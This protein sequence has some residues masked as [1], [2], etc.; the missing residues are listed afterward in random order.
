LFYR[1]SNNIRTAD[2]IYIYT[3]NAGQNSDKRITKRC[4]ENVAQF[5]YFGTTITNQNTI[6][7]EIKR[8]LYSG[9]ACYLLFIPEPLVF[10]SAV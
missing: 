5:R 4:R 1:I 9:N 2:Y 8:R 3:L 10:S 7:E 6:Q